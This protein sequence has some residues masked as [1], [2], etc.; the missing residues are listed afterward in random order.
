MKIY[1]IFGLIT[2]LNACPDKD[3]YCVSCSGTHCVD[4]YNSFLN[5][6]SRCILSSKTVENCVKY[7]SDGVCSLCTLGYYLN[8]TG[9]CT[10]ISIEDCL[11]LESSTKCKICRNGLLPQNGKCVDSEKKCEIENCSICSLSS[12]NEKCYFCNDGYAILYTNGK[13]S[14]VEELEDKT[15]NCHYLNAKDTNQCAICDPNYYWSGATCL[16]S[17]K[18]E[19]DLGVSGFKIMKAFFTFFS[20]IVIV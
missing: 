15:S 11:K 2:L 16:K 7:K 10:E 9:K 20:F 12:L 6:S 8:T 18:Y 1:I 13:T 17:E 19:V 5:G 3:E 14:C 4:C